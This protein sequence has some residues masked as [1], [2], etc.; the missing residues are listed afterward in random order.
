[1]VEAQLIL[2]AENRG[3]IYGC[4]QSGGITA[5]VQD[6]FLGEYWGAIWPLSHLLIVF[7]FPAQNSPSCYRSSCNL[8][9]VSN[10]YTAGSLFVY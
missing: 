8:T 9:P 3:A 1:M 4:T 6:F 2:D 7:V 10:E 5:V